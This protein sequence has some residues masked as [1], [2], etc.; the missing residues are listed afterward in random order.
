MSLVAIS[1]CVCSLCSFKRM[2][3]DASHA[4][5]TD[6]QPRACAAQSDLGVQLR[7]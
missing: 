4:A 3:L 7:H 1:Y 2:R 6:E 5:N